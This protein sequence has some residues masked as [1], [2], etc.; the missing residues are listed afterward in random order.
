MATHNLNAEQ[1][2]AEYSYDPQTGVFTRIDKTRRVGKDGLPGA[3]FEGYRRLFVGGRYHRAHR[4]AWLYVYGRWPDH[5]LDHIN[6]D[7]GDNRIE[8]LR[9]ASVLVN[10]ENLRS[11][12]RSNQVGMLGVSK[13]TSGKYAA[14]IRTHLA[15]HQVQLYLGA[16]DRPETAHSVYLDA[17]RK[18]HSGCSI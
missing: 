2:R 8:N 1:L 12:K 16:Y 18:L 5:P 15:G 6:G 11:A 17:K 3:V 7:R 13:T 9:E 4:L 14:T 10:N